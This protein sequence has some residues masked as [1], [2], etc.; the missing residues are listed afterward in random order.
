MHREH[1]SELARLQARR[2]RARKRA[3]RTKRVRR[4]WRKV[5]T[6]ERRSPRDLDRETRGRHLD[7][8]TNVPI[9]KG[10][11]SERIRRTRKPRGPQARRGPG[12]TRRLEAF[13]WAIL[14]RRQPR[15]LP[16]PEEGRPDVARLER[17]LA[18]RQ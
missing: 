8:R 1:V 13:E 3:R 17:L 16:A 7:P 2:H 10:A 6:H 4:P 15:R 9:V 12:A 18:E 5:R 11:P 14:P